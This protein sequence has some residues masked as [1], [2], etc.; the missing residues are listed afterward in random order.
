MGAGHWHHLDA[1]DK[2]DPDAKIGFTRGAY[3]FKAPL[4]VIAPAANNALPTSPAVV[5]RAA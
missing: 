1:S 4:T 2:F 5:A 3:R